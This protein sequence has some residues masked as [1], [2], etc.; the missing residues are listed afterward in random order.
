MKVSWCVVI[1]LLSV[2]ASQAMQK[3]WLAE[4]WESYPQK[5]PNDRGIFLRNAYWQELQTKSPREKDAALRAVVSWDAPWEHKRYHLVGAI[6]AGAN[7][8]SAIP[9]TRVRG[10]TTKCYE[11]VLAYNCDCALSLA[12]RH[13]DWELYQY[14]C[15]HGSARVSDLGRRAPL[16]EAITQ[17]AAHPESHGF[18]FLEDIL[19]NGGDPNELFRVIWFGTITQVR[20]LFLVK[21]REMAELLV[22]YGAHTHHQVRVCESTWNLPHV[23]ALCDDVEP[24]LFD[25]CAAEGLSLTMADERGKTPARMLIDKLEFR[26]PE[27]ITSLCGCTRQTNASTQ[28]IAEKM[29]ILENHGCLRETERQLLRA[30]LEKKEGCRKSAQAKKWEDRSFLACVT[31]LV[32]EMC[33]GMHGLMSNGVF[34]NSMAACPEVIAAEAVCHRFP[35][36]SALVRSQQAEQAEAPVQQCMAYQTQPLPAFDA[37]HFVPV[38]LPEKIYAPRN[39]PSGGI[40]VS[41]ALGVPSSV[42]TR[43]LVSCP[44]PVCLA[45]VLVGPRSSDTLG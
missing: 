1:V 5:L 13:D 21:T 27:Q 28:R 8:N 36:L 33:A 26:A 2:M 7:P 3:P 15:M 22:H 19:K 31:G 4:R 18:I 12:I 34:S 24:A 42:I 44:A 20:P 16:A 17:A 40:P 29:A 35:Q 32:C 11:P 23:Y 14:L 45:T 43:P 10:V 41:D 38:R 25:W 37:V 6:A 30:E 9:D 39:E